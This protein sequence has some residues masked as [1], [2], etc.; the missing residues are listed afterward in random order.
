VPAGAGV[1][2]EAAIEIR[3]RAAHL[4][5]ERET[6]LGTLYLRALDSRS[7]DPVLDDRMADDAVRR[8]DYDFG[9][10][11]ERRDHAIAVAMRARTLDLW[12]R[13]F[14][15]AHPRATVLHLGCGLDSRVHRVGPPAGARWFDV[16]HPEVIELRRRLY[17]E[18][19]GYRTIGSSV[20]DPR[21]L[22]EVPEG[23][24]VMV[25]AEGL[26]MYLTAPDVG[27]LLRRLTRRFDS[28][29]LAFDA[30]SPL[31][32]RLQRLVPV[33]RSTGASLRW[34]VAG[35]REVER[36]VPGLELVTE[37]TAADLADARALGRFSRPFRLRL[38]LV[39]GIPPLRRLAWILR[40][41][42]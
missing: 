36:L 19:D 9:R 7:A 21:W 22:D 31:G 15:A 10:F 20:T 30:V 5:G 13:E 37:L 16:D 18:R 33:V 39:N 28:G 14:L 38:R 32:L 27:R 6:M 3:V 12:V 23:G 26:L 41:R 4:T 42:F 34:G 35:P 25:V 1:A 2:R 11:G 29:Q 40:Y 8:I 24:P 17:P